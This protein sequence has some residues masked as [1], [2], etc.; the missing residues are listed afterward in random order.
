MRKN[1]IRVGK[2]NKKGNFINGAYV[3]IAS[4]VAALSNWGQL[5]IFVNYFS[6]KEIGVYTLAIAISNPILSLLRFQLSPLYVSDKKRKFQYNSYFS[7]RIIT[8]LVHVLIGIII[9]YSLF[10]DEPYSLL[11]FLIFCSYSIDAI[12]DIFESKLHCLERFDLMSYSI[13]VSSITSVL[14]IFIAVVFF[15]NFTIALF[16]LAIVKLLV[17]Y[18]YNYHFLFKKIIKFQFQFRLNNKIIKLLKY[19]FYLGVYVAID[20]L[21]VNISKYFINYRYG[22]EYQGAFSTMS[23]LVVV[24]TLLVTTIGKLI[25]PKIPKLYINKEYKKIFQYQLLYSVTIFVF[26]LLLLLGTY[27]LGDWFV[28]T[29]FSNSI[30]KYVYIFIWIMGAAIFMFLS[31]AQGY[32]MTAINIIKLQPV[33]ASVG[34]LINLLLNFIF[35]D[36]FGVKSIIIYSA[37]AFLI[38]YLINTILFYKKIK[39]NI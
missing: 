33:V 20:S 13:V 36:K 16:F 25:L 1:T 18:F 35:I 39:S 19:S 37:I 14:T 24:G 11:F 17:L 7:L 6:L 2:F 29:F 27:F 31:S 3:L 38:Q 34:L 8:S 30:S 15:S 5:I 12:R 22:V 32:L 10:F 4:I 9:S 26:G 28:K 21:N 23:Y